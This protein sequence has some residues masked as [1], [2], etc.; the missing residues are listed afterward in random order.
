MLQ[1]AVII[2]F[3][4]LAGALILCFFRLA[5]GPSFPDRVM[6]LDL[7]VAVAIGLIGV[8]AVSSGVSDFV[9]VALVISLMGFLGTVAFSRFIEYGG[10]EK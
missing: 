8:Y 9:D 3:A 7:I 4:L 6:T 10:N 2:S 1:I 5:A